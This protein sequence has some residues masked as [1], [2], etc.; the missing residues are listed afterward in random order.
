MQNMVCQWKKK[1]AL[2]ILNIFVAEDMYFDR[3]PN[4]IYTSSYLKYDGQPYTIS[5]CEDE[6]K[7][8][9]KN[10][11]ACIGFNYNKANSSCQFKETMFGGSY[12]I[13]YDSDWIS[14]DYTHHHGMI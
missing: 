7:E 11:Y 9:M 4:F 2:N 5:E 6:C 8:M 10:G 13:R 3:S 14:V 1:N 12:T